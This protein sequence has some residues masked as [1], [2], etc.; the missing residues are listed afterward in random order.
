[1]YFTICIPTYNR[2]YILN[3]ALRSLERQTFKDFEVLVV[4]DGS[5][6]NTKKFLD[7]YIINSNLKIKYFY[8]SNG[9]KHT[10][11]NLG[12]K[13]SF[14]KY[15]II[16]DLDDVL[17]ENCLEFFYEKTKLIDDDNNFCGVIARCADLNSKKFIGK[18]FPKDDFITSYIDIHWGS[19][20]SL[21]NAGYSDCLEAIKTKIL[22][23]YQWPEINSTKFIPEDYVT[24]QIGLKYQLIGYNNIVKLNEYFTDGIT[25]NQENYKK[26]NIDGYLEKYIWNVKTLTKEKISLI[27]RFRIW[28]Q[29]FY[30]MQLKRENNKSIDSKYFVKVPIKWQVLKIILPVLTILKNKIRKIN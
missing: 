7:N 10:A 13:E 1:M 25:K 9:G 17:V 5:T 23:Q 26:K 4:D 14:G 6:D 30:A 19:G 18:A 21:F 20:L 12:V 11:L 27:A 8:K 2:S 28:Y 22:K 15:F 3:R 29:Y 16:L 24:D